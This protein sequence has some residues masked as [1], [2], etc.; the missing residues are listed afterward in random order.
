MQIYCCECQTDVSANL[1]TGEQIY[2]H[3]PDLYELPFWQCPNCSNFVGCHH[4][5]N[6]PTKPLG[7]IPNAELKHARQILHEVIDPVWKNSIIRRHKLYQLI[8]NEL[9]Y[10]YHTAEIRTIEEA[11]KVY[12]IVMKLVN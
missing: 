6:N 12:H 7:V 9:G 11:R 5:T 4:K 10:T 1:V 3:R 2:P 8:S